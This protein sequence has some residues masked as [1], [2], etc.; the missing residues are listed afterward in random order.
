LNQ[1]DIAFLNRQKES[2]CKIGSADVAGRILPLTPISI[3]S[4][5][6]FVELQMKE[7]IV[8]NENIR[9]H[10]TPPC[11]MY[12]LSDKLK[13]KLLELSRKEERAGGEYIHPTINSHSKNR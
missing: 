1:E 4:R 5:F 9:Y 8:D 7:S 3:M 10:N 12:I 6:G 11:S 2:M 13:G